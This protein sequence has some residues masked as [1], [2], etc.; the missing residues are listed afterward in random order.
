MNILYTLKVMLYMVGVNLTELFNDRTYYFYKYY[1]RHKACNKFFYSEHKDLTLETAKY[2]ITG[3]SLKYDT[4]E[5]LIDNRVWT[6]YKI[7]K[8]PLKCLE[9]KGEAMSLFIC[10]KCGCIENT[11]LVS[12]NL[13]RNNKDYPNMSLM[14]MDCY[15]DVVDNKPL[16]KYYICSEC[17]TGKWHGEFEK[18]YPNEIEKEIAKYSERNMITPHDQPEGCITG[19]CDDYHVDERYKLFVKLFGK[20]VNKENTLFKIYLEDKQNFNIAC[21]EFLLNNFITHG[22]IT[23][24]DYDSTIAMSQIYPAYSRSDTYKSIINVSDNTKFDGWSKPYDGDIDTGWYAKKRKRKDLISYMDAVGSMC[25]VSMSE[26]VQD[27]I[28]PNWRDKQD[29]KEKERALQKAK[30][31]RQIKS[32]KKQIPVNKDLLMQLQSEYKFI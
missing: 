20:D 17:N 25:G 8:E 27:H 7:F 22:V 12:K 3:T 16:D 10:M 26:I 13:D 19:V 11:N 31:K 15:L 9:N 23:N 1:Y 6:K 18:S 30:L 21:L 5:E 4:L 32:L 14:E 28:K 24:A 29:P 2:D